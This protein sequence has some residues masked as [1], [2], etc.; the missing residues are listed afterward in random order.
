MCESKYS[1]IFTAHHPFH[2]GTVVLKIASGDRMAI[3]QLENEEKVYKQ[4]DDILKSN[5][6]TGLNLYGYKHILKRLAYE[7]DMLGKS[8]ALA[9][10]YY[11]MNLEQYCK[12]NLKL[13]KEKWAFALT[14]LT[15]VSWL[16]AN[17]ISH[18]DLKE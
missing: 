11:E 12:K 15:A 18:R 2:G 8:P 16:H 14:L 3:Q 17:N 1:K 5:P 13:P 10:S 9:L 6:S 7:K 4:I